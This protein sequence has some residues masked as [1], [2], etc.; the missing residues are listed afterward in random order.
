MVKGATH[1]AK[2]SEDMNDNETSW[3]QDE[4]DSAQ[5]GQHEDGAEDGD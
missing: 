3:Q 2:A 4:Q 5:D 1:A